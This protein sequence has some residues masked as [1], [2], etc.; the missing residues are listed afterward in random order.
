MAILS[1][2][3]AHKNKFEK[4]KFSSNTL[5][6]HEGGKI[7]TLNYR[8]IFGSAISVVF[9]IFALYTSV[10]YLT[11]YFSPQQYLWDSRGNSAAN[12]MEGGEFGIVDHVINSFAREK[13][14]I[15]GGKGLA[16]HY[17]LPEGKSIELIVTRCQP[18]LIVEVFNCTVAEQKKFTLKGQRKGVERYRFSKP[19]F[20]VYQSQLL[21]ADGTV[22]M[23]DKDYRV[24]WRR[25]N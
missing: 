22:S 4:N 13:A 1:R 20:Y 5:R 11:A 25:A 14:Y 19:G 3:I 23:K 9:G 16:V 2:R 7:F 6:L 17:V 18:M 10:H 15:R 12:Q 24:V 8:W 21:N